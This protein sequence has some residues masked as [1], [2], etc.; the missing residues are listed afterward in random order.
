MDTLHDNT[1]VP[2]YQNVFHCLKINIKGSL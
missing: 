2:A 1:N